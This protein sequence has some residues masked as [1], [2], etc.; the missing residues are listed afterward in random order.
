MLRTYKYNCTN[1][2]Y[3]TTRNNHSPAA[4]WMSKTITQH[5]IVFSQNWCVYVL[6]WV[7]ATRYI[8]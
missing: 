3:Y 5:K 1:R 2:I 7:R 6:V 8:N 4:V